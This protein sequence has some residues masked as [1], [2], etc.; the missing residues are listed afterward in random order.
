M[1][2]FAI[3]LLLLVSVCRAQAR[4]GF[5]PASTNV[6]GAAYPRV[7]GSGRAEC[8]LPRDNRAITSFEGV[9]MAIIR[10]DALLSA[11]LGRRPAAR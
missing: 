11:H 6:W 10:T 5:E 2:R 9:A 1:K 4:D 3:A 8:V 7:D